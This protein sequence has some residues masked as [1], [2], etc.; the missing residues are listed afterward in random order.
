MKQKKDIKRQRA[1]LL[2]MPYGT[3]EKHLR[4]AMLHSL[5]QQCGKNLCRWCQTEISSPDDLAVV[6]VQDW[7]DD[8]DKYWDLNNVAFSHVSC[9]AA[10]G[11]IQQE[12]QMDRI[13][14]TIVDEQGNQLPGVNHNGQVYVAGKEGQRYN[15]NVTNTTGKRVLAVVTVDGR[16]ILSGQKGSVRDRGYILGPYESAPLDGW[17]QTDE[18]VAAFVFGKKEGAYSSEQGTPQ[19]VGVIGVAVF[20]EKEPEPITVGNPFVIH[21]HHHLHHPSQPTWTV[22]PAV[23]TGTG[24]APASYTSTSVNV[25]DTLG[26]TASTTISTNSVAPAAAG[27]TYSADVT[28]RGLSLDMEQER[29]DTRKKASRHKRL[30]EPMTRKS[31][32]R[33][34]GRGRRRMAAKEHKQEIGTEYGDTIQSAITTAPF[35]RASESPC[36]VHE[37]RYDSMKALKAAGIMGRRPPK[38]EKPQ[39][40]PQSPEVSPGYCQPPRKRYR[41]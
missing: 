7:S 12:D 22:V 9:A 19:N 36:E 23:H 24:V 29:G 14:V 5:A 4:K 11:G 6:H 32:G 10:R 26:A 16:N 31:G 2:G 33:R 17:R 41:R 25:N 40:F 37:V 18:T 3:A 21:T 34:R 30:N 15:I 39:A 35:K 38:Q 8:A 1:A 13:K 27:A 20:E 28:T